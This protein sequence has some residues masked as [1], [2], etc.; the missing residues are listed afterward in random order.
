[1]RALLRHVCLVPMGEIASRE[2]TPDTYLLPNGK[3]LFQSS[4][5]LI[6]NC[7]PQLGTFPASVGISQT[8]QHTGPRLAQSLALSSACRISCCSL[9]ANCD[10]PRL[11]V[12]L[13]I[14]PVNWNGSL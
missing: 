4:F 5:I 2:A 11:K 12:N 13:S 14:F 6:T 8:R 1:M 10:G 9:L 7:G 3:I